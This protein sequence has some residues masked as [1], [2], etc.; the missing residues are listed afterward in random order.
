[1]NITEL[2]SNGTAAHR[3]D[4]QP[5]IRHASIRDTL[6]RLP[7]MKPERWTSGAQGRSHTVAH[8]ATVWTVANARNVSGDFAAQVKETL[9]FLDASLQQAGSSRE[10]LLSVQVI[11]ADIKDRDQFN[12]LW[13]Q[14]LGDNPAHW[15][16]R[17]VLGAALAPGLRLEIVATASRT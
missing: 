13:C 8:G 7:P 16:Q 10:C 9:A 11:L 3:S 4:W 5:Q 15:P 17:A 1:M 6:P 2:H 12:E 14:W